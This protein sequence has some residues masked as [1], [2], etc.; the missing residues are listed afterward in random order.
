MGYSGIAATNA[1][2]ALLGGG[3]IASGGTGIVGGAALLTAALT[4]GTDI[5]IS[6]GTDKVLAE[7]NY[8]KFIEY[9]FD[10]KHL[11]HPT[12][13]RLPM[14]HM[15]HRAIELASGCQVGVAPLS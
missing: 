9:K 8:S 12:P 10:L 1:G 13:R 2:L 11:S 7:Y 4:F 3:S 15:G 14:S 5:V 6:Y